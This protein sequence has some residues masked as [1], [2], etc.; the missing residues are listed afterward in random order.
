MLIF[1]VA[2]FFFTLARSLEFQDTAMHMFMTGI[3]V[4]SNPKPNFDNIALN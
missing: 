2:A 3:G 1:L 4:S